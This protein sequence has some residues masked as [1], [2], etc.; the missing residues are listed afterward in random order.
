MSWRIAE[1]DEKCIGQ[2]VSER[3]DTFLRKCR[4]AEEKARAEAEAKRQAR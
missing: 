4:E 1:V 3:L 2:W